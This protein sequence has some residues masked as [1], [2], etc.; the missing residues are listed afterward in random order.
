VDLQAGVSTH[1]CSGETSLSIGGS[2]RPLSRLLRLL[3][4]CAARGVMC[5]ACA[6]MAAEVIGGLTGAGE[7]IDI[8]TGLI[9]RTSTSD[10]FRG[11]K[12]CRRCGQRGILSVYGG[13]SF[14]RIGLG[15]I[16]GPIN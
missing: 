13:K 3:K 11:Y 15:H 7:M 10:I 9:R 1:I 5:R 4:F 16:L 12:A 2:G 14:A 8:T 6:I